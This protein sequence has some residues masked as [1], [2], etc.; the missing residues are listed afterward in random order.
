MHEG[1]QAGTQADT[2]DG[3]HAHSM[4]SLSFRHLGRHGVQLGNVTTLSNTAHVT[5]GGVD[6]DVKRGGEVGARPKDIPAP[7]GVG[8]GVERVDVWV[9]VERDV[10]Q[11]LGTAAGA[12]G[13]AGA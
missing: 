5:R 10:R 8:R 13:T 1:K 4:L 2:K 7:C 9:Q 6:V 11:S 3:A 12:R